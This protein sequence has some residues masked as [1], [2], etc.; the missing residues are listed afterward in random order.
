MAHPSENNPEL[1]EQSQPGF[2]HFPRL[3]SEIQHRI[4]TEAIRK[5]NIH[6]VL[7]K[8]VN[9][10]TS[11]EWRIGIYPVP[12]K[13]DKS[14]YRLLESLASVNDEASTAVRLA[15]AKHEARL[16]FKALMNRIDGAE[17]IVLIEFQRKSSNRCGY[18]HPDNQIINRGPFDSAAAAT[19]FRGFQKVG[20]TYNRP[21]LTL[22]E[23]VFR[24]TQQHA[25]QKWWQ[26][27][28]EELFG[29]LNCFPDLK[30][31][32]IILQPSKEGYEKELAQTY[33]KNFFTLTSEERRKRNLC[34]FYDSERSYLELSKDFM[35]IPSAINRDHFRFNLEYYDEVVSMLGELKTAFL[36]SLDEEVNQ[37]LLSLEQRKNLVTK[38]L[39]Q[40]DGA[41]RGYG[42]GERDFADAFRQILGF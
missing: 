17:D 13:Q 1:S 21:K 14:G 18:F 29:L 32:Y 7:A 4:F 34:I 41:D 15:T 25:H 5:P 30:E 38:V 9:Y 8:R 26:I 33:V 22:A 3:P 20:F 19:Q 40:T 31:I 42:D 39:L 16:P 37:Y 6:I 28:P 36:S 24:C 12:K 23:R 27:C 11:R 2:V 10:P 35:F